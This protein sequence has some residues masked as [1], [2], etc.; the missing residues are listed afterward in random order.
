[1]I[2]VNKHG[3]VKVWVNPQFG[4]NRPQEYG[5]EIRGRPL[6]L[7]EPEVV[8]QIFMTVKDHMQNK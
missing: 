8:Q 4:D 2:G 6:S 1:M 7:T 5:I 3:E